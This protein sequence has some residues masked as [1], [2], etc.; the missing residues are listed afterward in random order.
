MDTRFHIDYD[1]WEQTG[2][3]IRVDMRQI[4]AE[5]G[6]EGLDDADDSMMVDWIDPLTA[7][8]RQVDGMMYAFLVQC[9]RNPEFV[10]ERIPLTEAVFRTLLASGNRPMT[11]VELAERTG[12]PAEMILRTLSGPRVYKGLRPVE[13]EE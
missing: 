2:K 6:E 13:D 9:S 3:D 8:V 10:N 11:P 4:C 12:R 5:I 7:E 1:W